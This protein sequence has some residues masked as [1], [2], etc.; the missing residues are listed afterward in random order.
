MIRSLMIAAASA[1]V[2]KLSPTA[3]A[4]QPGQFSTADQARAML[5]KA[6]GRVLAAAFLLVAST[7]ARAAIW[8]LPL[9]PYGVFRLDVPSGWTAGPRSGFSGRDIAITPPQGVPLILLITPTASKNIP[10]TLSEVD[11]RRVVT[12]L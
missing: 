7:S 10:D 4:Q 9:G 1:V 6:V 2:L 8:E 12:G 3:F 5:A 11:V